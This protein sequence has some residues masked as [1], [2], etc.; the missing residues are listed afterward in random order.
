MKHEQ[1]LQSTVA[2]FTDK[3]GKVVAGVRSIINFYLN[4]LDETDSSLSNRPSIDRDVLKR[5]KESSIKHELKYLSQ[6][7]NWSDKK[8][9]KK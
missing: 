3:D 6:L 1:A 2:K 4:L 9:Y 7:Q 8:G 5:F